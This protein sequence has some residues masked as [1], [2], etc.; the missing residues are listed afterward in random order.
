M[1][2]G[3]FSILDGSL[4][5]SPFSAFRAI[6]HCSARLKG[7]SPAISQPQSITHEQRATVTLQENL[8]SISL[9]HRLR[10]GLHVVSVFLFL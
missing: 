4:L 8:P 6:Y 2:G 3:L 9:A 7:R 10:P 1:L 5:F